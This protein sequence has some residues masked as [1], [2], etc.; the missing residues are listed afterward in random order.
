MGLK[1]QFAADEI[2]KITKDETIEPATTE[3][4]SPILFAPKKYGSLRFCVNY[5]KLK[6]IAMRD[7]YPLPTMDECMEVLG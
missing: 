5:R 1:R 6:V 2:A 4:A 7:S 3:W